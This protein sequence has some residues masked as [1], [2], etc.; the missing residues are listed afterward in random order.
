MEW[1]SV[2]DQLPEFEQSVL[3]YYEWTAGSGT[4]YR[5]IEVGFLSSIT[6]GASYLNAYW[7]S[8]CERHSIE[9]SH[10]MPLPEKPTI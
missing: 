9:P 8:E 2:K 6:K 4:V 7:V 1:I 3:V 10:W 5:E